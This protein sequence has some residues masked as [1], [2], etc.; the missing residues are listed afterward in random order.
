[1]THEDIIFMLYCD[2]RTTIIYIFNRIACKRA[3]ERAMT[4]WYREEQA[5]ARRIA[6]SKRFYSHSR[7]KRRI[8]RVVSQEATATSVFLR[9]IPKGD[10]ITACESMS[11]VAK[12]IHFLDQSRGSEQST[13][14]KIN[15]INQRMIIPL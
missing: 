9:H 10:D 12:T 11:L 14:I 1:M 6:M 4:T 7:E 3:S 15:G 5:S 8:L 13:N 2:E